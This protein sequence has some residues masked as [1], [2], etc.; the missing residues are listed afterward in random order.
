LKHGGSEE[1]EDGIAK[2]AKIAGLPPQ[3]AKVG[4]A[5]GPGIAK[6][7]NRAEIIESLIHEGSVHPDFSKPSASSV[8]QGFVF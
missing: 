5:G 4:L 6:I 2:I 7:E 1:A 8:F 3:Q